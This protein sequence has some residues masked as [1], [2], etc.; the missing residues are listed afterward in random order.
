MKET[1]TAEILTLAETAQYLKMSEKTIQR[2]IAKGE[3][4]CAKIASQWRFSRNLLDDWLLS[5]MQVI[6]RNDLGT[7]LKNRGEIVP[8]NRLMNPDMILADLQG[9]EK[10]SIL[11]ELTERAVAH[12]PLIRPADYVQG[13]IQREEMVSTALGRGIAIPHLRKVEQ[14]PDS[15][16]LII[17]GRHR[18]GIDFGAPDGERTYIFFLVITNSE[19]IHLRLISKINTLFRQGQLIKDL[20]QAP[21][22]QEIWEYL[23]QAEQQMLC[24]AT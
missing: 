15:P 10:K 23:I 24:L 14:N 18:A 16:P 3:I 7:L 17:L 2:M 12:I 20:L 1:S 11:E 13:L 6:P 5:R 8:L 4:P 19:V 9:R 21:G 22:A